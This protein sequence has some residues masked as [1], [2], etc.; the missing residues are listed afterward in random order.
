MSSSV[1]FA[2]PLFLLATVA[3]AALVSRLSILGITPQIIPL[4]V[5]VWGY[6]RGAQEGVTW[7]FIGGLLLDLF[8]VTPLGSS[9]LT[10]MLA[11]LVMSFLRERLPGGQFLVPLMLATLAML[12]FLLGDLLLLRLLGYPISWQSPTNLP[13]AALF[14]AGMALPLLWLAHWVRRLLG[15][16]RAM[17]DSDRAKSWRSQPDYEP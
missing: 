4:I 9:A 16:R 7:A 12:T 10:L 8:S 5:I 13:L 3:Q 17:V 15:P 14:H 2:I 6:L 11:V 1:Y